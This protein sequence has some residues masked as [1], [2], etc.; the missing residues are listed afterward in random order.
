[1]KSKGA[2]VSLAPTCNIQRSV[3]NG[4]NFEC[5]SEDPILT[6][7]LAVSYIQGVQEEG[8]SATIQHFVGNESEIE[9]TTMS[10]DIDE[11]TLREVYLVPF[12]AAVKRGKTWGIMSSYNTVNGTYAAENHWLLTQVLRGDWRYDGV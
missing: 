1:M 3:T 8:I 6:G 2:H 11:H 7:E 10:S 5:C 12:E 4:R 9:R